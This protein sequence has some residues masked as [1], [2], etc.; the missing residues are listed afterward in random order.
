VTTRAGRKIAE[1]KM[2]YLP[3]ANSR[4]RTLKTIKRA[5]VSRAVKKPRIRKNL[6]GTRKCRLCPKR[7][8]TAEER[9]KHQAASHGI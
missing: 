4:K 6:V 3:E 9:D 2:K 1:G 8:A 5:K 7:F